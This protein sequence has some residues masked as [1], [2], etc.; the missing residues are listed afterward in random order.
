MLG[1]DYLVGVAAGLPAEFILPGALRTVVMDS[2]HAR[3][4]FVKAGFG[5]KLAAWAETPTSAETLLKAAH[6]DLLDLE[7]CDLLGR[8]QRQPRSDLSRGVCSRTSL[9][10]EELTSPS[11]HLHRVGTAGRVAG[12]PAFHSDPERT[13][14]HAMDQVGRDGGTSSYFRV[15]TRPIDPTLARVPDDPRL[16]RLPAARPAL[17]RHRRQRHRQ[18]VPASRPSAARHGARRALAHPLVPF[19]SSRGPHPVPRGHGVKAIIQ[20]VDAHRIH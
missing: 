13:F 7:V 17:I 20:L 19:R 4:G 3:A 15:S 6:T 14:L 9:P 11:P 5:A 16:P 18:A 1:T 8:C 12:E 10:R 2:A